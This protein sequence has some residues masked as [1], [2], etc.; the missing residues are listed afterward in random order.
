MGGLLTYIL[1]NS[2]VIVL[3]RCSS[4]AIKDEELH[5]PLCCGE[6]VPP[7]V[8][9]RVLTK[10]S[11]EVLVKGRL[12]GLLK[13]DRTYCAEPTCSKLNPPFAKQNELGIC[14]SCK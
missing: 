8:A 1:P 3:S 12:N 13:I 14:A 11:F 2:A 9:L 7:G 5:P 10:S 4:G 6:A